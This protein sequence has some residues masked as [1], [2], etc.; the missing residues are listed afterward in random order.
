MLS[1]ASCP[2]TDAEGPCGAAGW[3]PATDPSAVVLVAEDPSAWTDVSAA[4]DDLAD[5]VA[6]ASEPANP[7]TVLVSSGTWASTL[8]LSGD[9]EPSPDGLSIVGC[10][11][12]DSVLEPAV[13]LLNEPLID[14]AGATGISLSGLRFAGGLNALTI[15]QGADVDAVDLVVEGSRQTGVFV[16]GQATVATLQDVDII[17]SAPIA[18]GYGWG[19]AVADVGTDVGATGSVTVDGGTIEGNLEIGVYVT[20]GRVDL[21]GTVISGTTPSSLGRFGRG[22]HAQNLSDLS[23]DAVQLED[24]SDAAIFAHRPASFS[25]NGVIIIIVPSVTLPDS[26]TTGDGIVTTRASELYGNTSPALYNVDIGATELADID[27]AGV[28][29]KG[30]TASLGGTTTTGAVA[31]VNG[32]DPGTF[33]YGTDGAV[34]TVDPSDAPFYQEVPVGLAPLDLEE[35]ELVP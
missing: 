27:R 30:V 8:L 33:L 15:R 1:T 5:A 7:S 12:E 22:I 9:D 32:A 35:F 19:L 25:A 2:S 11:S 10:S 6:H 18:T 28:L 14:V 20:S 16:T 31:G 4:F 13:G 3:G 29:L 21:S 34:V 26:T 23:L 17:N 24:N